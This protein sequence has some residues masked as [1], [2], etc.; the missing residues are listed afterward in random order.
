MRL[1]LFWFAPLCAA[2]QIRIDAES[3][4]ASE[5]E[6]RTILEEV[7]AIFPPQKLP[8]LY[9]TRN[10]KG[11][12]TLYEKNI[13]GETV[14]QL[15]TRGTYWAQYIYQFA[16]ELT[17]VRSEFRRNQKGDKTHQWLDETLCEV[18]SLFALRQL[19]IKWRD[20]PPYPEWKPY[21]HTLHNYAQKVILSRKELRLN[22][23]PAFYLKQRSLLETSAKNRILNGTI[24][25]PLLPFFEEAP[26]RWKALKYLNRK[27]LTQPV[28]FMER[29]QHWREFCPYHEQQFVTLLTKAFISSP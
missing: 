13:Q 18:A 22:D 27:K 21:R 5:Q 4:E 2:A 25:N 10:L 16:H 7:I 14:I 11:P 26:E 24:A 19:S 17:H 20:H 28:T 29:L 8:P 9:I 3:F 23:L 12:I 6:I 15:S 1:L